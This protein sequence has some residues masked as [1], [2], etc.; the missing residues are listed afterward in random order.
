M[1]V[2]PIL[3]FLTQLE[4]NNTREWMEANRTLYEQTRGYFVEIVALLIEKISLF[5]ESIANLPPKTA[6]TAKTAISVSAK[7]KPFIKHTSGLIWH[8]A[9]NKV[10]GQVIIFT[11][12]LATAHYLAVALT[13][14][15]EMN[16]K[17]SGR[18]LTTTQR[19]F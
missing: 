12:N 7:T 5:D 10:S 17:I 18:K 15:K 1:H 8:R 6:F 2:Q 9:A 19:S 4:N 14:L 16:L 13:C 3:D 11:Y